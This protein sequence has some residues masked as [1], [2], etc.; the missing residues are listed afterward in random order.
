MISCQ[1]TEFV[2]EGS[3]A[4]W[5]YKIIG[6]R[7]QACSIRVKLLQAKEGSLEIDKIAGE[8]MTCYYPLGNFNYPE[9]DLDKC[10]G[11]LK[12]ALQEIII[13]KMHRYLIENLRDIDQGLKEI[14]APGNF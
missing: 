3:E 9:K 7:N 2:S 13:D 8:E 10:T 4:S 5:G 6:E 1:R 12:E 11:K 14:E